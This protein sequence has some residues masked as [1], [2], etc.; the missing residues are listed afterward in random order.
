MRLVNVMKNKGIFHR[1]LG[2]FITEYDNVSYAFEI[3]E[4]LHADTKL[5]CNFVVPSSIN[6]PEHLWGLKLGEGIKKYGI[7]IEK[8][9]NNDEMGGKTKTF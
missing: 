1:K 3:Y 8:A 5:P 6:W 2:G 7:I 9:P 4:A